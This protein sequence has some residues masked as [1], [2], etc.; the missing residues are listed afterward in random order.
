LDRYLAKA[1]WYVANHRRAGY[2][3]RLQKR[4]DEIADR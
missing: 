1:E 4:P 2:A 3:V